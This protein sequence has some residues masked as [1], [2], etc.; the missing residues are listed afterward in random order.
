VQGVGPAE[1][2]AGEQDEDVFERAQGA[3]RAERERGGQR[4]G[5][6]APAPRA[7]GQRQRAVVPGDGTQLPGPAGVGGVLRGA[8]VV[9]SIRPGLLLSALALFRLVFLL[10]VR[11]FGWLALLA[12]SDTS[13]DTEIVVLRHE[14]AVLRR[15]VAR[16][17]P[18]WA[19]RAVS[20]R[21]RGY[22]PA[23]FVY[24]GS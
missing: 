9:Q 12:Q 4:A 21:W 17:A 20:P 7:V 19:D 10:M 5:E 14:V 15:Q 8:R 22:C 1:P 11:L 6:P 24:T 16:P 18:D 13:K 3:G 23:T 2:G